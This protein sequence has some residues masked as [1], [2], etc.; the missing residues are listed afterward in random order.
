MYVQK[1]NINIPFWEDYPPAADLSQAYTQYHLDFWGDK[2]TPKVLDE[3]DPTIAIYK[4]TDVDIAD[5]I[6][7]YDDLVDKSHPYYSM[8]FEYLK[9][10]W[11]NEFTIWSEPELILTR[12]ILWEEF[13]EV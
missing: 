9:Y 4:F 8:L 5:V 7:F 3:N 10:S 1:P 12:R 11:Q 6:K 13:I 2:F